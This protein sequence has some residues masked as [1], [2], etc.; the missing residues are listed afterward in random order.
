M[1]A[2]SD[3]LPSGVLLAQ[4]QSC[5]ASMQV[6][7]FADEDAQCMAVLNQQAGDCLSL[8]FLADEPGSPGVRGIGRLVG[9]S[10]ISR[11]LAIETQ[12]GAVS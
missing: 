6:W 3:C 12:S 9:Y 4:H 5:E 10:G 1:A 11:D 7:I 2:V 8:E